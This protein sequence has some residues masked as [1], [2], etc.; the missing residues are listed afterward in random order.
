MQRVAVAVA[1]LKVGVG[2]ATKEE[3]HGNRLVA[4]D[5]SGEGRL[6]P[7]PRLV[8]HGIH[9]VPCLEEHLEP[10]DVAVLRRTPQRGRRVDAAAAIRVGKLAWLGN[11]DAHRRGALAVQG[12]LG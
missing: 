12:D 11:R 9:V 7:P 3:A 10:A 8:A 2:A 4:I 5:R 1:I 6:V